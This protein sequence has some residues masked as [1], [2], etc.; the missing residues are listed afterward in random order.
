MAFTWHMGRDPKPSNLMTAHSDA[1]TQHFYE[2][3]LEF[4]SDPRYRYRDIFPDSPLVWQSAEYEAFSLREKNSYPTCTCRSVSGTLTGAVEV[5]EG[6]WL[7]ADDLIKELEEALSPRRLQVKWEKFVNQCYDRRK[8]GSKVLMI[9]TRWAVE[10]P[11]GR[12]LSLHEGEPGFHELTIPALDPATG[13]SN[14]DYLY[15]LGFDRRYY[16]DMMRT[17]DSATYEAKYN[18]RPIKREGQLFAPDNLD[19]YL[20][21]PAGDPSQ[22]VA[23]VDTKGTGTDYEAMPVL[24]QWDGNPKWFLVDCICDN[25]TPDVVNRRVADCI[26][27]NGVM[28]ARFESNNGGDKYAQDVADMLSGIGHL[29]SVEKKRTSS[30]KATRIL[31]AQSWIQENVVFP[32]RAAY[33]PNGDMRRFMEQLTGYVLDGKNPHDDAPDSLSMAADMLTRR[34]RATAR[35]TAR[36]F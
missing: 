15:G 5:G 14:F 30:N 12:M 35:A 4:I 27:R 7:G 34:R 8:K 33:S 16:L 24:A 2:Q 25:G 29:C 18:G 19:R 26:A 17:T 32:D 10:D 9:G 21:V 11:I 31:A 28:R 6:G 1:L 22:V 20:T 23:A 36:R 3:L 13:E